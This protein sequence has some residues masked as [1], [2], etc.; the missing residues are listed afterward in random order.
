[1]NHLYDLPI[2]APRMTTAKASGYT[3]PDI[4]IHQVL[5]RSLMYDFVQKEKKDY[6]I[7]KTTIKN[8]NQV[9]P[10]M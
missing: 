9:H 6:T 4:L 8:K 3:S 2:L 7:I 1:M 5:E 10:F